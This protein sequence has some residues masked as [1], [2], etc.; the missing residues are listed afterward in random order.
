MPRFAGFGI[1]CEQVMKKHFTLIELLVVMAIIAILASMLLPA[2]NQAKLSGQRALCTSNLRQLGIGVRQ[3]VDTH[4]EYYFP[5][6]TDTAD[7]RQWWFGFEPGGPGGGANRPIDRSQALLAPF[8]N[9]FEDRLQ[10]PLFPYGAS[11]FY[12][13]FNGRVATYG[14]NLRLVDQRENKYVSRASTV[15]T[16]TDAIHFDFS[17]RFNE[18]HYVLFPTWGEPPGLAKSGY[19]H[20]RHE[21][22]ANVLFI[23]GHI[24]LQ[25]MQGQPFDSTPINFGCESPAGNLFADDGTVASIDG[26]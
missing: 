4:D 6:F 2:L 16:F 11:T 20:F 21:T 15:F 19:A 10:C 1:F 17:N 5:Y 8:V 13:K 22:A 18:G 26:R 23:D 12:E 14:Y 7:G 3:Y 9:S 25:R 24:A